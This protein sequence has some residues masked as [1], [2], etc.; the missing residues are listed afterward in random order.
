MRF[1]EVPDGA[2]QRGKSLGQNVPIEFHDGASGNIRSPFGS[3]P[4]DGASMLT[5][6]DGDIV[7]E[8]SSRSSS[9]RTGSVYNEKMVFAATAEIEETKARRA[10]KRQAEKEYRAR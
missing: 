8:T 7:T 4:N 3:A 5:S 9:M 6:K 10:R 2:K 1:T